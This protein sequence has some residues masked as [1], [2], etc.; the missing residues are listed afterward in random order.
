MLLTLETM[1]QAK[2][3]LFCR[4]MPKSFVGFHLQVIHKQIVP[5]SERCQN[6]FQE[7]HLQVIYKF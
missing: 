4:E 7:F 2:G 6:P 1:S 5:P 3:I